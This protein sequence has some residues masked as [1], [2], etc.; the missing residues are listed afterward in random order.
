MKLIIAGSRHLDENIV[1]AEIVKLRAENH[2]IAE[3]TEIFDGG[4]T[5]SDAAGKLYG[6]FYS[7]PV[8][9]F[10][11][12]WKDLDVPGAVIKYNKYGPYNAVAGHQRNQEMADKAD[13]L[14]LIWDGKSS[15]SKDMKSRMDKLGKPVYEV[16]L[17]VF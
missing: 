7:I 13:C 16:I 6:D 3:A 5:G 10:K 2:K 1:Y 14:L 8:E 15:G 9:L 12:K 4:A 11:A 17:N